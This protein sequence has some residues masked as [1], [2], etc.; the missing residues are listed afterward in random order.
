MKYSFETIIVL[1]IVGI[2]LIVL[3]RPNPVETA[4]AFC[5]ETGGKIVMVGYDKDSGLML[6]CIYP[7]SIVPAGE[8]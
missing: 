5:T 1:V 2:L 7:E 8:M 4:T 6:N 3:T